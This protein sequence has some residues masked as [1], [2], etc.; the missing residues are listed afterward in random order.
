MHKYISFIVLL[1]L[2][3][4]CKTKSTFVSL[5]TTEGEIIVKLY[6][7]TPLHKE[8]F[9]SL[10]EDGYYD[11]LLFHRVID[12]FM[13]QSGDPN[14]KN[15]EDGQ[16]LG[17]GGPDYKVDAEFN[18]SLFHKKGALAAAH[19]GN[20]E[21]S[22]AGSQFYI[23]EGKVFNEEQLKRIEESK[24]ITYTDL[25]RETYQTIGG[26]PPLDQNY[27]VFGEVVKGI[28]VVEAISEVETNRKDRPVE[29]VR[30]LK[31]EVIKFKEE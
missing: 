30:I 7:E 18:D 15:A 13:I 4:S 28:K 5:Q 25:Q 21:K 16:L 10:V 26:Y 19:D 23:V 9:I 14:S 12:E 3:S 11:S 31:A 20:P 1:L 17:N 6:E 2:F 27:T 8:N 22:S 29:N 24:D